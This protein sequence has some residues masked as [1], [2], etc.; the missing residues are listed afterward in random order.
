MEFKY[1]LGSLPIV[2]TVINYREGWLRL[3]VLLDTGADYTIFPKDVSDRL[4]IPLKKGKMEIIEGAGHGT[5]VAYK[6]PIKMRIADK[7][8]K[9]DAFFSIRNDVP[10]NIFGREELITNFKITFRRDGFSMEPE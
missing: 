3:W 9:I 8:I 10:E 5:I 7:L 6:H 1:T 4:K 2:E